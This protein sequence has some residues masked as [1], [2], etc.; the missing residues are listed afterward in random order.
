MMLAKRRAPGGQIVARDR[1]FAAQAERLVIRRA[2]PPQR[3]ID[4]PQRR[5]SI[6]E[7]EALRHDH[8]VRQPQQI[9]ERARRGLAG[10][11]L[12]RHHPDKAAIKVPSRRQFG[13]LRAKTYPAIRQIVADIIFRQLHRTKFGI[14][15]RG[16]ILEELRAPPALKFVRAKRARAIVAERGEQGIARRVELASLVGE[17]RRPAVLRHPPEQLRKAVGY[18]AAP[19]SRAADHGDVQIVR[20]QS[21]GRKSP[22]PV[23]IELGAERIGKFGLE[24]GLDAAPHDMMVKRK[25]RRPDRL[26][27]GVAQRLAIIDFLGVGGLEQQPIER[28]YLHQATIA[29]QQG[30]LV[31]LR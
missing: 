28:Q 6:D 14:V 24:L 13:G 4:P 23:G 11:F 3:Q 20:E 22:T 12:D 31:D 27:H 16:E 29:Q 2:H 30:I 25:P 8:L 5:L 26:Q 10:I 1:Q 21:L 19:L 15:E 17:V 18:P 7:A 9:V